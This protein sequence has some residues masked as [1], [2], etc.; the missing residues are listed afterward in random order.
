MV[1]EKKLLQGDAFEDE[2]NPPQGD[3]AWFVIEVDDIDSVE[4]IYLA[5]R[6]RYA[7]E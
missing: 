7:A 4:F 1:G 5:Y 6:F 3:S 2:T